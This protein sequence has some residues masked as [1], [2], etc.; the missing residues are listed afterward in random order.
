MKKVKFYVGMVLAM[1]MCL[2]FAM[3]T[4]AASNYGS[5]TGT[6][7]TR[8]N[9]D[10]F[11]V[12]TQSNVTSNPD[13]A[14][15]KVNIELQDSDGSSLHKDEKKSARG[16]LNF[17]C[18]FEVPHF[19]DVAIVYSAHSIQGGTKYDAQVVYN[20]TRNIIQ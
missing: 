15:F 13:K 8:K 9:G 2:S 6:V 10:S 12:D 1:V 7:S 11:W 17:S 16:A 20:S 5:L 4:F 18:P 3:I 14:Y 19:D